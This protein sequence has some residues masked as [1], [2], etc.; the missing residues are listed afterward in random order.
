LCEAL[1]GG[2][3]RNIGCLERQLKHSADGSLAG[4]SRGRRCRRR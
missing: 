3:G 4:G 1:A 2:A